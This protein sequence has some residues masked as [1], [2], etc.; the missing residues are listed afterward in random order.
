[1]VPKRGVTC[2]GLEY[3]AS[4]KDFLWQKSDAEIIKLAK[5]EIATIGLVP[6]PVVLDA[7]VVRVEKAY[8]VY[9]QLYME[10]VAIV[11]SAID[12]LKNLQVVG[13]NGMHKYNNQDHSMMTGLL[14]VRNLMG[15]KL[16][17]W[18]VNS[19]AD[20]QEAGSLVQDG[21]CIPKKCHK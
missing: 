15:P 1:M 18:R 6:S 17:L 13:R 20:Y 7:C 4:V 5:T 8:P 19:D 9:D 11:R 3:F 21:R 14:A 12:P 10:N 16:D 2:L